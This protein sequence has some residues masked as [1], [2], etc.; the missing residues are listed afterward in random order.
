VSPQF[1]K[2]IIPQ[3]KLMKKIA[4]KFNLKFDLKRFTF[5]IVTCV[6]VIFTIL[7]AP[8]N[9]DAKEILEFN[10]DLKNYNVKLQILDSD[11][12]I[13]SEFM[14]AVADT[15]A[16][17]M[18]GLMK[19][20]KLP[21]DHGMLFSFSRSQVIAMWMKNTRIPL[22]MIFIDKN[23]EI[24]HI[25]MNTIPYSLEIVSSGKEV[26]KVLEINGGLTHK[27]GIKVGQKIEID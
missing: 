3:Q 23:N 24:A 20:D 6:A 12:K 9:I 2:N 18:Y 8:Q 7:R 4:Q 26:K 10:R 25:E 13:V 15:E 17:K 16:K 27:L 19:L 5:F 1:T 11:K 22:D 14:V 21:Q